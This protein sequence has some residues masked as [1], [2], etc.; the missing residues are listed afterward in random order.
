MAQDHITQQNEVSN[1]RC[2]NGIIPAVVVISGMLL[3]I[4]THI[5]R[6]LPPSTNPIL[7]FIID[8]LPNFGAGL[9]LPF[10][11]VFARNRF[12]YP[13]NPPSMIT[14]S[15]FGI[16]VVTLLAGWEFFQLNV[17]SIPYDINDLYATAAGALITVFIFRIIK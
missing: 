17:W 6:P 10:F 4:I 8:V 16:C 3:V 13:T 1:P 7:K 5:V 2:L 11:L 12:R 9:A 15:V 14:F